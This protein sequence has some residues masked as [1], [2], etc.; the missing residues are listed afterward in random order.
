[1]TAFLRGLSFKSSYAAPHTV[2]PAATEPRPPSQEAAQARASAGAATHVAAHKQECLRRH[3]TVAAR[4]ARPRVRL[5]RAAHQ[6]QRHHSR[7]RHATTRTN[8]VRPARQPR[9]RVPRVQHP[10]GRPAHPRLSARTSGPS[11]KPAPLRRPFEHDACGSRQ[12]DRRARC[13][14]SRGTFGRSGLSVQRLSQSSI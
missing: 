6:R 5:L 7:S 12:G 4:Q 3:A 9:A 2:N 14:G 11:G 8:R 13:C 1:M 10:E